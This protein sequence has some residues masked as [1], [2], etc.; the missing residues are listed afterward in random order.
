MLAQLRAGIMAH[1][2]QHTSSL[3]YSA[4]ERETEKVTAGV[5]EVD[6]LLKSNRHEMA[7]GSCAQ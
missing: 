5:A 2:D 3:R 7:H 4:G 1:Q 6:L